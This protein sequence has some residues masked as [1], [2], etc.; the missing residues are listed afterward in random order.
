MA[1]HLDSV[2]DLYGIKYM[3]VE[4]GIAISIKCEE[5]GLQPDQINSDWSY[6]IELSWGSADEDEY[7]FAFNSFGTSFDDAFN[8]CIDCFHDAGSAG[9]NQEIISAYRAYLN[10]LSF[11]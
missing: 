10:R 3:F 9:N 8:S 5:H 6:W 4:S 11:I 1:D 7:D 2:I